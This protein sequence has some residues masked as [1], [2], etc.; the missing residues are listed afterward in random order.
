LSFNLG[1]SQH[2]ADIA[3]GRLLDRGW[4][5]LAS[6][7]G[8]H[9]ASFGDSCWQTDA[10][11]S[12]VLKRPDGRRYHPESIA[13]ARRQL[14]DAGILSSTRVFVGGLLPTSARHKRSSRGT[15]IKAFNW[16]AIEQKN[17]FSRRE[18]RLKRQE[19]ARELREAGELQKPPAPRHVSARAIVDPVQ[20]S[21]APLDPELVRMAEQIQRDQE[22]HAER[23]RELADGATGTRS[24]LAPG[25]VLPPERPPPE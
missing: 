21:S 1:S 19:Q 6:A 3:R 10:R 4:P 16:R 2:A 5:R 13:R 8:G 18:R 23:R 9:V 22:R 24:G 17:P 25:R 15:T 7:V 14:R 20:R 12:E 11:L